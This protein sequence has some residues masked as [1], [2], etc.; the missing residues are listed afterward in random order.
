M[1]Y[2]A[3]IGHAFGPNP[4]RGVFRT[5]DGGKSW[6][7]ILFVDDSTGAND[8]SIDP[9]NPRI[10]FASMWKFQRSPWGMDAGGGKSGLWKS[11]DGG[12]TL[13]GHLQQPR[14]AEGTARQDRRGGLAGQPAPHLRLGGGEG[15]V[16][17]DLSFR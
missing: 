5:M 15:H 8:I 11:T 12:D 3:A 13:D 2:V 6:K 9:T 7:K 14:N 10:I 16:R 17:R 4:E 1:A